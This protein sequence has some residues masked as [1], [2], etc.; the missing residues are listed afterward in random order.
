MHHLLRSNGTYKFTKTTP[1]KISKKVCSD[2][3]VGTT[4]L[5]TTKCNIE[6]MFR[7]IPLKKPYFTMAFSLLLKIVL[8]NFLK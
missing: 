7:I 6:K 2:V 4:K 1:E 5:A 3:K 8:D